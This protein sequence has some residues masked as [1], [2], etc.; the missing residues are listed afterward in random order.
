MNFSRRSNFGK[1]GSRSGCRL[2]IQ[3][4]AHPFALLASCHRCLFEG[5]AAPAVRKLRDSA[6]K[7]R[8]SGFDPD[9]PRTDRR[10]VCDRRRGE[11]PGNSVARRNTRHAAA[12][13]A[14]DPDES[15]PDGDDRD[16]RAHDGPARTGR[17]C[18]GIAR[19]QPLFHAADLRAG[20]D[21]GGLADDRHRAWPPAPFGA[22]RAPHGAAGPVARSHGVD[23]DL[24]PPLAGRGRSSSPWA[25]SRGWPRWPAPTCIL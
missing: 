3:P 15:R 7:P 9:A 21:D 18:R 20:P 4:L 17:A 13:L 23:P 19:R 5:Q 12:F 16:R 8:L 2:P 10:N 1:R 22:R 24:V 6:L 11:S 14:D 25:R